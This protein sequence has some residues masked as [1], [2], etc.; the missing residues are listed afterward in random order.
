MAPCVKIINFSYSC[1][2]DWIGQLLLGDSY[3]GH[4]HDGGGEKGREYLLWSI[5]TKYYTAQVELRFLDSQDDVEAS[6]DMEAV[7]FNCD[8]TK[9]CLEACERVW[10]KLR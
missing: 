3:K 9:Q 4:G 8:N 6:E 10:Q 7:I 5:E 1:S 2:S